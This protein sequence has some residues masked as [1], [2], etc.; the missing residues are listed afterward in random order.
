[1]SSPCWLRNRITQMGKYRKH[2]AC[3]VAHR[4]IPNRNCPNKGKQAMRLG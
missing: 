3:I 1:V 2:L 4:K